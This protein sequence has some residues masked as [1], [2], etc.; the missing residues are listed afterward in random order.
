MSSQTYPVI[1]KTRRNPAR[2]AARSVAFATLG[3]ILF[4][5]L[6]PLVGTVVECLRRDI[7]TLAGALLVQQETPL[8][9]IIDAMPLIL[10]ITGYLIGMRDAESTPVTVSPGAEETRRSR[11][12]LPLALAS[13]F[14]LAGLLLFYA[15]REDQQTTR[16]AMDMGQ[17]G[18]LRDRT[19]WIYSQVGVGR[20][21][22]PAPTPA[23]SQPLWR[24][25][26]DQMTDIR[27]SLRERYPEEVR[28]SDEVFA[29]F[30]G[31]LDGQKAV[32]W[33]VAQ[34]MWRSADLL[35]TAIGDRARART[36][37]ASA[38]MLLGGLGL[39]LL[40]PFSLALLRRLW[41]AESQMSRQHSALTRSEERFRSLVEVMSDWVWETDEAARYVYASPKVRHTMGYLPVE[42]IGRTPF[43]FM[44]PAEAERVSTLSR[45]IVA[46]RRPFVGFECEM[47]TKDGR[48]VPMEVSGAPLLDANGRLIGYRGINRDIT[49]RK[50]DEREQE[51][52][53][54]RL[55]EMAALDPLT[56][57]ANRRIFIRRLEDAWARDP[58]APLALMLLDADRF[59]AYNDAFGHLEGDRALLKIAGALTAFSPAG[60]TVARYGGEEFVVLL[61]D[62]DARMALA[63]AE[64]LR[65]AVASEDWPLRRVTASI[66]VA[67]RTPSMRR[68]AELLSIADRALYEAK[69]RGRDQV[70]LASGSGE[71]ISVED[72]NECF[73]SGAGPRV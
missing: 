33:P 45:Q 28:V 24:H 38:L 65:S 56:G 60:A 63:A 2:E 43:S 59:K 49:R 27:R 72:A 39:L 8:L 25:H 22:D 44:T 32:T 21:A 36:Q 20:T 62:T 57:L 19:L 31:A 68:S 51:L 3:G 52:Y 67:V 37:R 17:A 58:E 18:S 26:L 29:E 64:R 6:F 30:S 12:L 16:L 23:M 11:Q 14:L 35:A 4:G 41:V 42:I 34:R 69:N 66:G 10:G 1:P 47:L 50:E 70:V 9:W 40:L 7:V 61:P 46:D 55:E 71:G 73:A 48:I 13:V 15:A 5:L 53:R 54:A